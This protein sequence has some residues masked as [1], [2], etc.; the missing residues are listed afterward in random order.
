MTFVDAGDPAAIEES[1]RSGTGDVVHLQGPAPQQLAHDGVGHLVGSVG[2][3]AW[4]IAFSSLCASP[5][6][7]A[8]D[9]AAAFTRAFE[10][11]RTLAREEH[12]DVVARSVA[13]YL[14]GIDHGPLTE[15]ISAY[16]AMGTWSGGI[17]IDPALYGRTVELFQRF[18]GL[19]VTP[20]YDDVVAAV[21]R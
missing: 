1:F 7:L 15:A 13:P 9:V 21:P 18:G 2:E 10:K 16:Q 20:S 4:E 6:W 11:G 8:T 3:A 5:E 12:P 19:A 17:E 14:P